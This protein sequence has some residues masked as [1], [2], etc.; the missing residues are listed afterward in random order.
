[1]SLNRVIEALLFSAQKP[2]SP[3]EMV[4]ALRSAGADVELTWQPGGHAM[5]Q[6]DVR[7]ARRWLDERVPATEDSPVTGE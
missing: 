7:M 6:T 4:A 5:T 3:R 1:M 2:L